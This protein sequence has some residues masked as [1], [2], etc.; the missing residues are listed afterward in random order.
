MV[1]EHR[2]TVL[3][4]VMVG[5]HLGHSYYNMIMFAVLKIRKLATLG[6]QKE[7]AVPMGQKT[8]WWGRRP[9]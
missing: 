3:G 4:D 5:G 2:R 1:R 8:R 6:F 9:A 7:Q